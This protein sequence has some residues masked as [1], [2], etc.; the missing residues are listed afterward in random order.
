[1]DVVTIA[2]GV[3]VFAVAYGFMF[4]TRAMKRFYRLGHSSRKIQAQIIAKQYGRTEK[5]AKKRHYPDISNGLFILE[6]RFT[7]PEGYTYENASNVDQKLYESLSEGDEI[8]VRVDEENWADNKALLSLD[9]DY[10]AC[11][12][13]RVFLILVAIAAIG[14]IMLFG[15]PA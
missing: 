2:L 14:G 7:S 10:Q 11:K 4:V 3:V 12:A 13:L 1:M 9:R 6:Y 5:R 8:E 15:A